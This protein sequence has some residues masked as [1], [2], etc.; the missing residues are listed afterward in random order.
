MCHE[1]ESTAL[2]IDLGDVGMYNAGTML[3]SVLR[4]GFTASWHVGGTLCRWAGQRSCPAHSLHGQLRAMAPDMRG[5]VY[6]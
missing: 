6:G 3:P 4:V 2:E 5:R 1:T